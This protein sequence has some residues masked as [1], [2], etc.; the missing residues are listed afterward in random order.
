MNIT[1]TPIQCCAAAKNH[2]GPLIKVADGQYMCQ[3]CIA[4]KTGKEVKGS[5]HGQVRCPNCGEVLMTK[6]RGGGVGIT[7]MTM[8]GGVTVIECKCGY[9]K[10]ISSPFGSPKGRDKALQ[11]FRELER[12]A[13]EA[14]GKPPIEAKQEVAV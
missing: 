5:Q 8:R 3:S 13:K 4:R 12:K 1:G 7:S 6:H 14:E 9:K 10:R 11:Q 2:G